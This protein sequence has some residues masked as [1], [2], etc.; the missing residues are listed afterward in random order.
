MPYCINFKHHCLA[1]QFIY[2]SFTLSAPWHKKTIQGANNIACENTRFSTLFAAGRNETRRNGCFRRLRTIYYSFITI[3]IDACGQSVRRRLRHLTAKAHVTTSPP[4]FRLCTIIANITV[5]NRLV[6]FWMAFARLRYLST[7]CTL[8]FV[9][10]HCRLLI[11]SR[12]KSVRFQLRAKRKE[13]DTP[14]RVESESKSTVLYRAVTSVFI[15]A[16]Y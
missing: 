3:I 13:T 12:M 14:V 1:K 7:N 6:R 2:L 16:C 4:V 10:S 11:F 15:F 9:S 5:Q 8:T